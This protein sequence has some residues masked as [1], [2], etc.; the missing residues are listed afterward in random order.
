MVIHYRNARDWNERLAATKLGAK[1][2]YIALQTEIWKIQS[3]DQTDG[4][5]DAKFAA[6]VMTV[7]GDL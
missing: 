3:D 6:E 1:F 5:P 4:V 2:D 7:Y